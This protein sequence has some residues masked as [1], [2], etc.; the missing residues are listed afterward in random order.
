M[1]WLFVVNSMLL[2]AGL[3]MDAFSVSCANGLWEPHMRWLR[4]AAIAGVYAWFQFMMPMI[5]WSCVRAAASAFTA[6]QPAIP[7]IALILLVL[8]GGK[9]IREGLGGEEAKAVCTLSAA[10]LL[11][12]G[13]AT[14]IDALSVGFTL[15]RYRPALALAASLIIAAVTWV[16]C[17]GGL[18][19]GLSLIHI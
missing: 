18:A 9:M 2:G 17:M 4:M 8:I 13:V 7:W 15:A 19:I 14:S 6:F 12:Q 10:T 11:M 16:I 3:A 1:S 5:G